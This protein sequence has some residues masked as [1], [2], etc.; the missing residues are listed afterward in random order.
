MAT[1]LN[2]TINSTG[3][4]QI[5]VG[6]TAQRPASPE[7]G[8][9]RINTDAAGY[10]APIVE[11]YD[12]SEWKSLYTPVATGSGGTVTAVSADNVHSFTATGSGLFE[13]VEE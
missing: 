4:L 10:T 6:T 11:Y 3:F 7:T 13:V 8:M 1:L 12:G 9:I 2:T 5:A